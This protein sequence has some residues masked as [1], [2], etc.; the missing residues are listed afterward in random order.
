M[1]YF[2]VLTTAM[3]MADT[4][5]FCKNIEGIILY[6][7]PSFA[8]LAGMKSGS[9][10]YVST[11]S[12]F[13]A[14]YQ[15]IEKET[16]EHLFAT[17][18]KIE[19]SINLTIGSI[20][21]SYRCQ[22]AL[23]NLDGTEPFI[24]VSMKEINAMDVFNGFI[25]QF[26]MVVEYSPVSIVIT[27]LEGTIQYVN[28]TFTQVTG[29]TRE[30]AI[31][32]NPR[33]LKSGIL[34]KDFYEELWKTI[35]SGKPWQGEFH[36]ITKSGESFWEIASISPLFDRLGNITNYV[37]RKENITYLK[38][39]QEE[40][41]KSEERNREILEAIPD[42][43][44]R[45]NGK[46][47]IL[48]INLR[49]K[50]DE[51]F[52]ENERKNARVY[53]SHTLQTGVMQVYEYPVE[54]DNE[55][56]YYEAR[57]IVSGEDEVLTIIRNITERIKV[58]Q[59]IKSAREAA[60]NANRAKSAFLATMSHE[61]RT[62]LHSISGF[63]ELMKKTPLNETQKEYLH[64][65]AQSAENLLRI[66]NDVLDFSKIESGKMEIELISFDPF[67]EFEPIF[68]LFAR[69]ANEKNISFYP[70]IEPNL[71]RSIAS[72]PLRIRQ[73]L[74]NLLSNAIKF[75]PKGGKIFV[76]IKPTQETA[77]TIDIYFAVKD[78]GIGIPP[79]KREKIFE[80][81]TQADSSVTRKYGGT[82]LG[83]AISKNLV[84]L[85]GG[86]ISLE[87]TPG[88][89]STF[90]FIIPV[91][92]VK[93]ER[94]NNLS[95]HAAAYIYTPGESD[96]DL[97]QLLLR[98]FSS[99]R[100]N[101]KIIFR[102]P[103]ISAQNGILFLVEP[104]AVQFDYSEIAP[105]LAS[106]PVPMVLIKSRFTQDAA[107]ELL[108]VSKILY[109]PISYSKLFNCVIEM[110]GDDH[111]IKED[112]STSEKRF[113]GR[114]TGSVLV[115][116]DNQ[117]NQKLIQLMLQEYGLSVELVN[118]GLDA[119]YQYLR[120]HYDLILMDVNMPVTDGIEATRMIRIH[121]KEHSLARIPIIA[122]TAQAMKGDREHFLESG[123]DG[124]LSKPIEIHK[125]E[126]TLSS[127]F[128]STPFE[129]SKISHTLS[130]TVLGNKIEYDL[131]KTAASLGISA[132]ALRDIIHE[133]LS[134]ANN[135]IE[136]LQIALTSSNAQ[137]I[138][139]TA[140][141]LKGAAA[142]LRFGSI[143]ETAEKME[144]DAKSKNLDD[145]ASDIEKIK[146]LFEAY[147][148]ILGGHGR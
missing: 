81:F 44:V 58:E 10:T 1:N 111:F 38:N 132:G 48:D 90:S 127:I 139:Q 72:D 59:Q 23:F 54:R 30:E 26:F 42:I 141:R 51:V 75:T 134:G 118:N 102:L 31:G 8:Q 131:E 115:A 143:A 34:P 12:L 70:Y 123:M 105:S 28:K 122:L 33:I 46:G 125:L 101:A 137:A 6:A 130:S 87:S 14:S 82:G 147:T 18:Q 24:V 80:S 49:E 74:F 15:K 96:S 71:P 92:K 43:I 140:H 67:M 68:E 47:E 145:V 119:Y 93:L 7:N 36:N 100:I 9:E 52:P 27:D 37:A 22:K 91:K 88:K 35:S 39:I 89:G 45:L 124:Y 29:Y 57:F 56:H 136:E 110:L 148:S 3:D 76:D 120:K 73:V 103:E 11:D 63:I 85:L 4:P 50:I 66:I 69:R 142:N 83:L 98:Y 107:N 64:I 79:H 25:D 117:V 95:M 86:S 94:E 32:K 126:E 133:F 78:T 13:D 55:T 41:R 99:L 61:I 84:S 16:D 116:E 138:Q 20:Q 114:F 65:I 2:K 40:L 146:K 113:P 97:T 128:A 109:Q 144:N 108:H 17:E 106:I 5:M 104:S 135:V 53:I 21:K 19:Y 60:E 112:A 121:E 77:E 129:K 62:P